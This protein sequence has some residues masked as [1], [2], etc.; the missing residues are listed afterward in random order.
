MPRG[1]IDLGHQQNDDHLKGMIQMAT[2]TTAEIA[3]EFGIT[4]KYLRKFLR[5]DFRAREL[6]ESL[7]GKGARYAIEKRELKGLNSRFKKWD[8]E[9]KEMRATRAAES[10]EKAKA[11]IVESD[12]E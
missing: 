7:P 6:G 10:A 5:S 8:A 12:D 1:A 2:L 3:E 9:Q 11:E 4:P